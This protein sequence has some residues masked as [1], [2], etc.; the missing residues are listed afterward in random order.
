MKWQ[1]KVN[2]FGSPQAGVIY[3][4]EVQN[5]NSK[6][7]QTINLICIN[8]DDCLWR[9]CDDNSEIDEYNWDVISWIKAKIDFGDYVLIEMHRY[10]TDNEK[11][12]HKVVN[13]NLKSNSYVDVPVV[14]VANET[15]HPKVDEVVSC[16]CC[17]VNET[18]V[19]NYRLKDVI[20]V[21]HLK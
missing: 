9:T 20:K 21:N 13:G 6:T 17:G 4:C 7:I 3:Q 15:L 14:G 12:L 2:K 8:E 1:D 11:Y 18:V 19:L 10:G 5:Y 16:I